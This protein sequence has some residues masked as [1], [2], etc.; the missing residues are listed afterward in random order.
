M[1]V[2]YI[3]PFLNAFTNVLPQFGVTDIKKGNVSIRNNMIESPGVIIIV[4]IAGD[5]R[6]NVIYATSIECA[7][8]IAAAMMMEPEIKDF[9]EMA[10]S[11]ISELA[12]MLTA[13]AAT[14]FA[15]ELIDIDIST[16][17]LVYGKFTA[18]ALS[19][20]VICVQMLVYGMPFEVNISLGRI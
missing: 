8:K 7:K 20:K 5:M 16:P 12:N 10:Q 13:N 3:N 19:S 2:K 15:N 6:G 1:D 11:A 4:G 14:G 17:T 18:N 9:D